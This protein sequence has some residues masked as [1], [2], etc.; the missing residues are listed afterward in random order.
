MAEAATNRASE[1]ADLTFLQEWKLVW[2][3]IPYKGP[4]LVLFGVWLVLFHTFG[5]STL[6]YVDTSSLFGWLGYVYRSSVDNEHGFLIPAVVLGLLWWKRGQL[7]EIPK[8]PWWPGLILLTLALGIHIIGYLVQ[9]TRLSVVAFFVGLYALTGLMWGFQWLKT[10]FFPFFLFV[11]CVPLATL[12]EPITFPL[13]LIA[14]TITGWINHGVLGIGV[15]CDGTRIFDPNGDYQYE[16]AAACSGI[17]SLTAIFALS[18][19]YGFVAFRSTWKRLA[20]VLAAFP[21]AVVA[22]VLRL[23]MIIVASEAFGQ[24]SGEYVH[25]S[26]W[27]S[28]LP[29]LLALGGVFL[30]GGWFRRIS[31]EETQ[32]PLPVGL[33]AAKS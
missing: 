26:S 33:G 18:L 2:R 1:G 12:S 6:G 7:L 27:L 10:T 8:R 23:T 30:L 14:T 22:N 16:V 9:Q 31:R 4:F 3:Q 15:I 21:L 11:F 25:A 29:Y 5:N 17:R 28:L 20:M 19:I 13:R 24:S 32:E